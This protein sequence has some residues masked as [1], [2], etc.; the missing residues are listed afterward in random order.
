M[1]AT[2]KTFVSVVTSPKDPSFLYLF[3]LLSNSYKYKNCS[4]IITIAIMIEG[5]IISINYVKV[6]SLIFLL[7]IT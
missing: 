7:S 5:G 3:P 4:K 1:L 2:A 6:G